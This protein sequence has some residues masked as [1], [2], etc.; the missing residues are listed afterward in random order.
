MSATLAYLQAQPAL[1]NSTSELTNALTRLVQRLDAQDRPG[2]TLSI[3]QV[4]TF[5]QVMHERFTPPP[6][7]W[8]TAWSDLL[9]H[10]MA[11]HGLAAGVLN[12]DPTALQHTQ[13]AL[14]AAIDAIGPLTEAYAELNAQLDSG[15]GW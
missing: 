9:T 2:L 12:D 10:C 1:Q 3:D 13:A 6:S 15:S 5:A 7:T 4:A 11:L 14:Q 8:T